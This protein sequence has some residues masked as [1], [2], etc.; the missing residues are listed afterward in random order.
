MLELLSN[1]FAALEQAHLRYC[2][3][4]DGD[5]VEEIANKGEID[6]LVDALDFAQLSALLATQGF[7]RL[8]GWGH[9]PHTFFVS[10]SPTCDCWLKLDVVTEV[11]YGRPVAVLAT[12]LATEC[13]RTRRRLDTVF[14]PS[15]ECELVTIL[16]H[17]LLDKG[18]FAPHR[19]KRLQTLRG[20]VDDEAYLDAL[21]AKYGLPAWRWSQL[22]VWIDQADWSVLLTMRAA[23]FAHLVGKD[24]TAVW[25][26]RVRGQAMRKFGSWVNAQRPR[27][28]T[29][30]ILAPDGAGKS[31]L[32]SALQETFYFPVQTI[33][34]GLYQKR[35]QQPEQKSLVAGAGFISRLQ[36]QWLRYLSAQYHQVRRRLVIYDRYTYDVLLPSRYDSTWRKRWRRWLLVKTCPAPDLVVFLDAPGELLYARKGEHTPESLE[37]QRQGY[38]ALRSFLPQMAVVNAARSPEEIRREVTGLIWQGYLDRQ[39][40][41]KHRFDSHVYRPELKAS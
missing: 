4:R 40:D 14:V 34:M 33:Y 15:P 25:V 26:R 30:A 6:L 20:L 19:V 10:Y 7:V 21:L 24:R 11:R 13:L 35:S 37:R 22:V 38:L 41:A 29:V 16:L 8:P 9:L 39:A 17:C 32:V 28:L 27:S 31:T 36:R 18:Q 12:D 23:L 1:L 2:L 3:L 5:R